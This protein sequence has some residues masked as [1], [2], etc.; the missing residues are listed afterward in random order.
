[1][2][3]SKTWRRSSNPLVNRKTS[4]GAQPFHKGNSKP[5]V[6]QLSQLGEEVG[7]RPVLSDNVLA[8]RTDDDRA[9]QQSH[10]CRQPNL[11]REHGNTNN[12]RQADREFLQE[13]QRQSMCPKE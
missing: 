13:G 1:M 8:V 7:D 11:S 3:S 12:E 10:D 2:P 5:I 6:E 9:Q 4:F